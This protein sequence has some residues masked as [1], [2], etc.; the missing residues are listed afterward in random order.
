MVSSGTPPLILRINVSVTAA[1]TKY[2]SRKEYEHATYNKYSVNDGLC[3]VNLVRSLKNV[4]K[5]RCS[6]I[7]L[8][9]VIQRIQ[10]SFNRTVLFEA[11]KSGL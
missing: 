7:E 9:Y 4:F 1:V 3:S 10:I 8:L 5:A 11:Q 2:G 6:E